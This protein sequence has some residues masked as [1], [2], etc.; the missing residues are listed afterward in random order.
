[1]PQKQQSTADQI[2]ETINYPYNTKIH[3]RDT[4]SITIN[5]RNLANPTQGDT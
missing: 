2:K 5:T 4:T 3:Q 1:M